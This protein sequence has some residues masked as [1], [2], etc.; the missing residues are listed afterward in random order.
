[1][2]ATIE[3]HPMT[4]AVP[5]Q[6]VENIYTSDELAVLFDVLRTRG[7]WKLVAA[8]HFKTAEEYLAVAGPKD[9]DPDTKL[10]L[11]DLLTP[12]FR[13]YLGD[14]GAVYEEQVHDLYYNKR[15]LD[16]IRG[17]HGATYAMP[18]SYLFNLRA[19]AHSYDAG[20][21]DGMSW[22]GVSMA[23][24]PAW[25]VSVMAKSGLFERWE[26]KT[27]QV[28]AYFYR[29][30]VDGGFTYWPDGP[31]LAPKRFAAPFWNNGFLTNNEKMYHRGEASGPREK[32]SNAK[33]QLDSMIE[34]DGADQWV[35]RNGREEIARYDNDEM[36]FLFH[37]S[38][39]VFDD[40][41]DLRRYLDHTDD[42]TIDQ[43]I[44]MLLRDL[45]D[46]GVKCDP[47]SDPLNDTDFIATL[48]RTYAMAPRTYPA[49]APLDVVSA[50]R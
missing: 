48:S 16:M 28:I 14:Q 9:R 35:I 26:V 8:H 43:V 18:S 10:E 45:A 20:H 5:P 2:T 41:A 4:P 49:E 33:L 38:A 22:R 3:R 15:F 25:L 44:D 7:P 39:N 11:S 27:G 1:M 37:Y 50:R 46:R 32:R 17:I 24:A 36:R 12:T 47:S 21:F 40:Y 30:D 42:L 23:N 6:F 31:D 29:S 34:A 13:S 19:P